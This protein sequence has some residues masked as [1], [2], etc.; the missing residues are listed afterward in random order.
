VPLDI[1]FEDEHLIVLN[2]QPGL[3]V[4][5]ARAHKSGTLVNGLAWHFA[6][7]SGGALSTVGEEFARPGVVHRLDKWDLGRDRGGQERHGALAPGQ[8]I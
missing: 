1:L 4:H 6:H 8:A 3:I 7:V 5:P 2:K